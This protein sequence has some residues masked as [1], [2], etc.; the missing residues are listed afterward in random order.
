MASIVLG[1]TFPHL[2][3]SKTEQKRTVL[4]WMRWWLT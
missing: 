1:V 4:M 2:K 3:A